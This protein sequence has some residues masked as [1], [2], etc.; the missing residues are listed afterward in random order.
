MV[1]RNAFLDAFQQLSISKKAPRGLPPAKML[2]MLLRPSIIA[3][4]GK[5]LLWGDWS[6]I[7]ARVLPWL[8]GS[9][10]GDEL[11]DVFRETDVDP[12]KP[13]I[14]I[15]EAAGFLDVDMNELWAAYKGGDTDADKRRQAYGKVPI[16][17]LGFG[18]GLGALQA[19]ATNYGVHFDDVTAK[20]VVDSWRDRNSWARNFWGEHGRR[21]SYGL[22][23]AINTAIEN[24]DTICPAGRVAYVY[25]R[26]Y[27]GGTVFCALPSGR[28]LTYPSIKWEWREVENKKTKELEDRYQL[29]FLKGYSRS[30]LWYGKLAENVT[31]GEAASILR[32]TLKRLEFD[33]APFIG[34]LNEF[35]PVVMH[36]H[37]EVVTEVDEESHDLAEDLLLEIMQRN[38]EWDAD[39]PLKA[40]ITS[41]WTYTKSK[42]ARA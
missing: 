25:D 17:S 28:L 31:Q 35:M 16:L 42:E 13:D 5:T 37:D 6:A 11:L 10:G 29:T 22:W 3:R 21:G 33:R 8:A 41:H 20:R 34:D 24:P 2:S 4:P 32:R 12:S 9:R 36:T 1:D 18:G 15:R 27:L 26:S 40:E 39:L 7:E 30:A 19:M 14:Y 23:G 38:D